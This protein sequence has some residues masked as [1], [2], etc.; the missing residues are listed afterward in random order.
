M[1]TKK[2]SKNGKKCRVTFT[3][4]PHVIVGANVVHVLG[5]FNNWNRNTPV[6][7]KHH[8]DGSYTATMDLPT[9]RRYEFRY[10]IDGV[11]WISDWNA[12]GVVY[13]HAYNVKNSVID[14]VNVPVT[15]AA[16]V[17]ARMRRK[18]VTRTRTAVKDDL[19]KIEG[20]GP[21][22]AEIFHNAGIHT[23]ADLANTDV[24]TQKQILAAAG[25]RFRM[26]N[27]TTWSKQAAM[28][29]NGDWE[30]LHKWQNELNGGV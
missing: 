2:F 11:R 18:G 9:G 3:V 13:V 21:K 14:I 24:N 29:A 6:V 26:H 30:G 4:P 10:L 20:I 17:A 25:P 5:D 15:T 8:K 7:M 1:I 23:F 27:P 28:A 19:R 16:D 12:D 22:I